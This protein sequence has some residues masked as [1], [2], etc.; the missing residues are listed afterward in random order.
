MA[1]AD[2]ACPYLPWHLRTI[3]LGSTASGGHCVAFGMCLEGDGVCFVFDVVELWVWLEG[4]I[5][6]VRGLLLS[7]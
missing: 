7:R 1:L 5:W 6:V 2:L 3:C 4:R